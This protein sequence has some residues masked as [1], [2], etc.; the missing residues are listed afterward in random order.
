MR[1]ILAFLSLFMVSNANALGQYS[2][3]LFTIDAPKGNLTLK[4]S[5]PVVLSLPQ[6][7]GVSANVNV[8]IQVYS[9]S[10]QQYLTTAKKTNGVAKLDYN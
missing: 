6:S 7:D 3:E 8:H 5:Q 4:D 9:G 2:N 10:L 1:Y